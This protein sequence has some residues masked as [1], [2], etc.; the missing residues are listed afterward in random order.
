MAVT[1]FIAIIKHLFPFLVE[2]KGTSGEE[3]RW[4]FLNSGVHIPV[5]F[6]KC[7][8]GTRPHTRS[9][10]PGQEQLCHEGPR[11]QSERGCAISAKWT[12]AEGEKG[13]P[14]SK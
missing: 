2:D 11:D 12:F 6:L 4:C 13:A 8:V 7:S 1:V 14:F 10:S 5:F 9:C 3:Q